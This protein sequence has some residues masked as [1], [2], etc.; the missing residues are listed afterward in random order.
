MKK[1]IYNMTYY[2]TYLYIIIQIYLGF[3]VKERL[4]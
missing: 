2:D 1:F 3:A 4:I